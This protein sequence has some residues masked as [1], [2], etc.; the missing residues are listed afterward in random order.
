[1]CAAERP[2]LGLVDGY[3][4]DPLL[5]E[6]SIFDA[7]TVMRIEI[8]I[9]DALPAC[10][11]EAQDGENRVVEVTKSARPIRPAVVRPA[12]GVKNH[13]TPARKFGRQDR[14]TDRHRSALEQSG[15]QRVFQRAYLVA[16]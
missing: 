9:H 5:I 4:A 16:L 1:M 10:A 13:V 14:P 3:R 2:A 7:V 6:K 11:Q 8:D 15:E 12:G